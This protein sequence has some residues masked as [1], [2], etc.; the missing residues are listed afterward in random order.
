[1]SAWRN[2][3]NI[4][5]RPLFT[6]IF[7]P[8]MIK[9]HPYSILTGEGKVDFLIYCMLNDYYTTVSGHFFA[10]CMFIF[11]K[12]EVQKV[13]LRY[14]TNLN[15]NMFKSYDTKPKYFH[16]HFLC[17]FCKKKAQLGIFAFLFFFAFCVITF[18]PNKI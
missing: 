6:I 5:S 1:V 3:K 15:P 4:V 13:S 17:Q 11:H 14:L 2:F 8:K 12:T 7:R 18:V 10:L 16:F 9:F